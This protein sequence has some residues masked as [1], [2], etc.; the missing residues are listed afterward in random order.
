MLWH[1]PLWVVTSSEYGSFIFI[2]TVTFICSSPLIANLQI[3]SQLSCLCALRLSVAKSECDQKPHYNQY[4]P[5][6]DCDSPDEGIKQN[7]TGRKRLRNIL[8]LGLS[9]KHS[10]S[11]SWVYNI[12][13]SGLIKKCNQDVNLRI[14]PDLGEKNPK[15]VK[16]MLRTSGCCSNKIRPSPNLN[17][18]WC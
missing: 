2:A 15:V 8:C 6:T 1:T 13:E 14:A 11:G 9:V 4:L 5:R 12:S 7:K 17:R 3:K 16:K 10:K 18:W